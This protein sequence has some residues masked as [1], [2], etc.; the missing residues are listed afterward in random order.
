MSVDG[1]YNTLVQNQCQLHLGAL[2]EWLSPEQTRQLWA[3]LLYIELDNS[4]LQ[5]INPNTLLFYT[6]PSNMQCNLSRFFLIDSD[7]GVFYAALKENV[8]LLCR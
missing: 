5:G 2:D 1:R 8:L 3:E 4:Y 6:I 7:R